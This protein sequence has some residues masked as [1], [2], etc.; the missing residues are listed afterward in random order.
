MK[1]LIALSALT[2]ASTLFAADVAYSPPVGGF[3]T[4]AAAN[5]D[6]LVSP[7]LAREAAWRGTVASGSGTS[8]T[9]ASAAWTAGQFAPGAETYYVRMLS[10]PLAGQFFV[11]TGNSTTALTVD[12]AGLNLSTIASGDSAEIA[13]FWTLGTLY[14]ASQAGTAFIASASPLSVQTQLLFFDGDSSGINRASSAVYYF[15]NGAWRKA[16]SSSTTSFNNTLIFPDSYFIQRNKA[17]ATSLVYV[18]RV[19]PGALGTVLEARSTQNDNFV[20]LSFPVNVTLDQSGLAAAITASPSPL[21]IRDQ[22][23]V[24]PSTGSGINRAASAVYYYFNGAWR[25]AGSSSTTN[26]GGDVLTAGSGFIIRKA[27]NGTSSAWTYNTG[28]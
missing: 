14:P 2:F 8:I 9:L 4:T 28:F 26:F 19:Q 7:T 24:F 21:S 22:L 18:G 3:T 11:I 23:L 20:A 17:S 5:T 13:P 15:F 6:T 16:G 27:A 25:K 1:K 10:G 12:A